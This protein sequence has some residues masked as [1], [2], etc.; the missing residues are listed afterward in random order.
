MRWC[1][2]CSTGRSTIPDKRPEW[3]SANCL[4]RAVNFVDNYLLPMA[5][6]TFG[7]ALLPEVERHAALLARQIHARRVGKDVGGAVV[8]NRRDIQRARLQGL[9]DAAKVGAVVEF[10]VEAGWLEAIPSR[11][12]RGWSSER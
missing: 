3:V 2:N 1:S 4:E 5:E 8:V 6:R 11:A 7:D 12:G 9:R 10:L